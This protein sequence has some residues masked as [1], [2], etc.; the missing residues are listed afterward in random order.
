M[1]E[2][3]TIYKITIL[4]MLEKVDFPLSNTQISNFFLEHDYTDY[5]TI[6]QIISGLI[7]SELIRA[8]S[9]HS[10]TQYHITASGKET[11]SFFKDKIS[12]AIA[13]DL[14]KYFEKN[15]MDLKNENSI[16]A[17]FYKSTTPGFDVR[18]QLKEKDTSIIDLTIHVQTRSQAEAICKNWTEQHL[19][20]YAYLMDTLI[21]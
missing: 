5:F 16:V 15:K 10:N 11:L 9:T 4:E 20:V 1:A 13:E 8:E 7:D 19:E 21:R 6:Q 3:N 18:C 2:P 12:P 17:D 14:C